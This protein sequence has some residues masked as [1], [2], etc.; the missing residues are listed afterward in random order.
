MVFPS[1]GSSLAVFVV[2]YNTFGLSLLILELESELL[3]H[4][5]LLGAFVL[6]AGHSLNA[7]VFGCSCRLVGLGSSFISGSGIGGS[8]EGGCLGNLT[9]CLG[10]GPAFSLL[11]LPGNSNGLGSVSSGLAALSSDPLLIGVISLG[12]GE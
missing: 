2:G 6:H 3:K 9:L 4:L 5:V 11:L 12:L 7:M 10:V 1:L 8:L